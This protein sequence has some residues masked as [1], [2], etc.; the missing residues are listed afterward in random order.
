MKETIEVAELYNEMRDNAAKKDDKDFKESLKAK[1][2][3]FSEA[4]LTE[5]KELKESQEKQEEP[6]K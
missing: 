4:Q 6:E 1:T 5:L 2:K 3:G